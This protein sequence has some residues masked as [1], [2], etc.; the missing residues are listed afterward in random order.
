[1]NEKKV[2]PIMVKWKIIHFF[3]DQ[4]VNLNL[5]QLPP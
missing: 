2:Q 4:V 1:M 5:R 3:I